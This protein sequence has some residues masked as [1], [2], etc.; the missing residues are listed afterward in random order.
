MSTQ[1]NP[2]FAACTSFVANLTLTENGDLTNVSSQDALVDFFFKIID[3]SEEV[4]V[5]SFLTLAWQS[6]AKDALKLIFYLLDVRDGKA[7]TKPALYALLWLH[8][9]H[10]KTFFCKHSA[11]DKLWLHS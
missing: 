2:L 3:R 1:A 7:C 4:D 10:P 9:H 11:F 8:E 5:R 6:N